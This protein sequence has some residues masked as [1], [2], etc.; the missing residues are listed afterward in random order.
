V[1]GKRTLRTSFRWLAVCSLPI[2]LTARPLAA[3]LVRG[4]LVDRISQRPVTS[5]F[6]VLIDTA[7]NELARSRLDHS[8]SFRLV[9]PAVGTYR[10]KT[11]IIG[12]KSTESSQFRLSVG[13]VL[14]YR[15]EITAALVVLPAIIVEDVR[16]CKA[17][18][19]AGLAAS[20]LWDEARKALSAVAWTEGQALFRHKL[21]FYERELHPRTLAI[22]DER[23]WT[24]TG[25]YRGSPFNAESVIDLAE[26]GYIQKADDEGFYFYGPD[27]KVLLSDE[28]ADL[29]CFR[30]RPSLDDDDLV[31]LAFE[32]IIGRTKSDIQGTLWID[33][34]TAELRF[35]E[36]NYTHLPWQVERGRVGG[37]IE[38][39]Q[40]PDGPW[41]VTRWW[42]RM[43]EV[44]IRAAKP[45]GDRDYWSQHE[46]LGIKEEGGWVDEIYTRNGEPVRRSAG[47]TVVGLLK[48]TETGNPMKGVGI[49]LLGT[50]FAGITDDGGRFRI[51]RVPEGK[52]FV[53]LDDR[54]LDRIGYVPPPA[55]LSTSE[56]R[57][58]GL[59]LSVATGAGAWSAVCDDVDRDASGVGAITG[60]VREAGSGRPLRGVSIRVAGNR[61]PERASPKAPSDSVVVETTT[62]AAGY[63]SICDVPAGVRLDAHAMLPTGASAETSTVVQEGAVIRLDFTSN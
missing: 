12:I 42:I 36:F 31:G 38:F 8:G 50:E 1:I 18:S 41:I 54:Y 34:Y 32:P 17:P 35:L 56:G 20:T 24:E 46:I 13:Q 45:I 28:F 53:S 29:H 39:E 2:L 6:V 40:L 58:S 9:A 5:G 51:D 60:L 4:E 62:D 21:V 63:Y 44:G 15:F 25:L 11:Q 59:E 43:P 19:E 26:D 52:Y 10:L 22:Q 23:Q 14:P 37:R 16:T 47:A 30:P 27:A 48:E 7:G 49:V 57:S 33:K 61:I 3:Q 55:E